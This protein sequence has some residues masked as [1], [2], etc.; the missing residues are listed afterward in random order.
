MMETHSRA[1]AASHVTPQGQQPST[2]CQS[3][4]SELNVVKPTF[5]AYN[6]R[7]ILLL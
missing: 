2:T 1:Q 4:G 7:I 3:L 6:V 5:I